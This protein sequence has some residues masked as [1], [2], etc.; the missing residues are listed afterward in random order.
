MT[1]KRSVLPVLGLLHTVCLLF[2]LCPVL[3]G[4]QARM[5]SSAFSLADARK[6]S[7]IL[8]LPA[9]FSLLADRFAVRMWQYV[10]CCAAVTALTWFAG[11]SF[12]LPVFSLL[13]FLIRASAR[14]QAGKRLEEYKNMPLG[15][16]Q[17]LP[18]LPP[19]K[20]L[21]LDAPHPL[22]FL[23]FLLCYGAA[24]GL[25]HPPLSRAVFF[26][27]SADVFLCFLYRYLHGFDQYLLEH[28]DIAGLPF[29]AF[30]KIRNLLL[31]PA[32]MALLLA[33]L[34]AFLYGKEPL[35]NLRLPK[36]KEGELSLE[37]APTGP[38]VSPI[39]EFLEQRPDLYSSQ[40]PAWIEAVFQA[41]LW[42]VLALVFFFF[43]RA[44]YLW[45]RQASQAFSRD[46]TDEVTFLKDEADDLLSSRKKRGFR[47]ES[48]S[49]VLSIRRQYK[50]AVL[51]GMKRAKKEPDGTETPSELEAKA[52][53]S[54]REETAALHDAYE[55][56]R[57][58]P[59][60]G[61]VRP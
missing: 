35:A 47:R 23:V 29:H 2:A 50:K 8:I 24:L 36:G 12:L 30:R 48:R 21:F 18:P 60:T 16:G 9:V 25:K 42:V 1:K 3:L 39:G 54:G 13:L 58:G 28:K 46:G 57:Y 17:E 34:P 61:S 10:L 11:S 6:D 49:P 15:D 31:L 56:A 33:L 20:P 45:L 51:L 52:G 5:T 37:F 55:K 32:A 40:P 44:L 14:M 43:L 26:S 7:C 59:Q 19:P 22:Q 38:A 27:L 53:I 41:V 4:I